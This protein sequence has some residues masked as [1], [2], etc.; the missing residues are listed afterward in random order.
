MHKDDRTRSVDRV[1]CTFTP[2]ALSG[3]RRTEHQPMLRSVGRKLASALY[4]LSNFV[5]AQTISPMIYVVR[6][7]LGLGRPLLPCF[8]CRGSLVA[9]LQLASL[10]SNVRSRLIGLCRY[11]LPGD[12]S[13]ARCS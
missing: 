7:A 12:C 2:S 6:A 1:N 10:P 4:A 8:D 13:V 9:G 3:R 11:N 5:A